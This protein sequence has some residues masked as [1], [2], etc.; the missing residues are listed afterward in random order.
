M[1]PEEQRAMGLFRLTKPERAELEKW[2]FNLLHTKLSDDAKKAI[3][4]TTRRYLFHV[5]NRPKHLTEELAIEKAK[6]TFAKEGHPLER[7]KLTQRDQSPTK[8]PG[9][10]PDEFFARF[11]F[12]PTVFVSKRI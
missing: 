11:V 9:G 5:P 6:L 12:R 10:T 1:T 8:A 3:R 2:L 4:A 7:W